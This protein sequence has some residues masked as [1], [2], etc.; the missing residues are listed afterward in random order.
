MK[1]KE[2]GYDKMLNELKDLINKIGEDVSSLSSDIEIS[3]DEIISDERLNNS[4][5]DLSKKIDFE[6]DRL[7]ELT[8]IN[9][10]KKNENND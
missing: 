6:L 1:E 3:N 10:F 5:G 2:N 8:K 4:I 7:G 9:I